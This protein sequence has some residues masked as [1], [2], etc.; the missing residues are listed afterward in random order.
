VPTDIHII[1]RSVEEKLRSLKN[2]DY[3]TMQYYFS[4]VKSILNIQDD[5]KIRSL[6][7]L[8]FDKL[9]VI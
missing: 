2:N 6:R 4:A 5:E 7:E 3:I 1:A 9:L 8:L